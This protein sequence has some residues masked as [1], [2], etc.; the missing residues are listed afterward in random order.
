MC[1]FPLNKF[2]FQMSNCEKVNVWVSSL[3]SPTNIQ[4][5]TSFNP[6]LLPL[7]IERAFNESSSFSHLVQSCAFPSSS[8]VSD[9]SDRRDTCPKPQLIKGARNNEGSGGK[10]APCLMG[11]T[12]KEGTN[13]QRLSLIVTGQEVPCY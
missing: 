9:E 5:F 13:L 7:K 11:E 1:V 8:S 6:L 2:I 10:W 12:H 3:S 4:R